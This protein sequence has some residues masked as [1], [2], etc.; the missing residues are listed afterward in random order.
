MVCGKAQRALP[1][2]APQRRLRFLMNQDRWRTRR[3]AY[4][5]VYVDVLLAVNYTVNLVLLLLAARFIGVVLSKKRVCLA[6]LLGA[7]GALIVFW[8]ACTGL[9]LFLFKS[10]LSFGM[11]WVAF[12]LHP[13]R[14]LLKAILA[15]LVVSSLFA[16][17]ILG[18]QFLWDGVMYHS[19]V[20]YFDISA[21]ELIFWVGISY[22]VLC[23]A[24][25][26]F[27]RTATEEALWTIVVDNMGKQISF[28][29]LADTGNGLKE[30]FSGAPVIICDALLA[31]KVF[32]PTQE[33]MR[34]IPCSTVSG[35]TVLE[36]F[37]PEQVHIIRGKRQIETND[38]YIAKSKTPIGGTYEAVFNPQLIE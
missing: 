15:L 29:A 18:L 23:V 31:D 38:V 25:R 20:V 6:A 17:M 10:A 3:D 5:T 1:V 30:P 22:G 32:A 7:L 8:P 33:K 19:G 34:L 12:G 4:M 2:F 21:L 35:E 9:L 11:A 13:L 16:G 14:K 28:H 36:A 26:F 24:E 37:R 27:V